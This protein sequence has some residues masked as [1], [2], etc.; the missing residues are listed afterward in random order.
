[1]SPA[2]STVSID[3]SDFIRKISDRIGGYDKPESLFQWCKQILSESRPDML[4]SAQCMRGRVSQKLNKVETLEEFSLMEKLQLVF[5]FSSSV[6]D[7]FVQ[8]L[9][10]TKFQVDLDNEKRISRFSTE[11]G[12]V[13]RSSDHHPC[14]KYF[15][16]LLCLNNPMQKKANKKRMTQEEEEIRQETDDENPG[17]EVPQIREEIVENVLIETKQE[18]MGVE[19]EPIGNITMK[20]EPN[21]EEDDTLH[22]G[23]DVRQPAFNGRINYDEL[24]EQEFVYP[25]FPQNIKIE[26]FIGPQKRRQ[27]STIVS[28]K[29]VKTEE[30][31]SAAT[32]S[33]STSTSSNK[34]VGKI[35]KSKKIAVLSSHTSG[36][37]TDPES[38]KPAYQTPQAVEA[39]VETPFNASVQPASSEGTSHTITILK[40][41]TSFE[42]SSTS[43]NV[44]STPEATSPV[45]ASANASLQHPP[46]DATPTITTTEDPKISILALATHIETIAEYYELR[47]L[48]EKASRVINQIKDSGE[49]KTFSVKKFNSLIVGL[50]ICIEE[51]LIRPT[52]TSIPL[53]SLLKHLQLYLIRPLESEETLELISQKVQEFKN[54][55]EGVPPMLLSNCLTTLLIATGFYNQL[56]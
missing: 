56:D 1:M 12:S 6:S 10:N 50:L 53:K 21:Q 38:P 24:D 44:P 51:N 13:V 34:K 2:K 18:E 9:R 42:T 7:E 4:R 25:G 39:S 48:K 40:M 43:T 36:Q 49:K 15:K 41:D 29:R 52:T 22:I 19:E 11:D 37:S 45:E 32:T 20:Q 55:D 17:P 27:S 46:I 16:G 5:I 14:V 23:Q 26:T 54:N 31:E 30:M 8:L 47:G 35:K 3:L 33:D 28:V